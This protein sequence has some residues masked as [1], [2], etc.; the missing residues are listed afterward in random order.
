MQCKPLFLGGYQVLPIISNF[1]TKKYY[2]KNI[3]SIILI[4]ILF[5]SC[6]KTVDLKYKSNTS[7]I[8]IEGNITNE[9]IP[10]FVKITK[11]VSL[12]AT[13]NYPTIDNAVV[14][15]NDNAGN[16]ETLTPLGNGMYRT[17][18]ITGV[19]GRTYTLT[20]NAESKTYT[21]QT[22]MPLQVPFDSIKAE[23]TTFGGEVEYNI[24]PIYADPSVKGNNY[25]FELTVNNKL[26]NQHFVQ[27]DEVVNGAVNAERLQI[28]DNT[29]KL[30]AGD[31][32]MLKMQCI[33]KNVALYYTTL[34]LIG[35]SGPGGGTTPNNPPNNISNGALGIFSAHTVATK[36]V[37]LR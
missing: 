30:K 26:V 20:V 10:H 28:D 12:T 15:I 35:D 2:M 33:D 18:S 25:R 37:T 3:L 7:R 36:K 29:L 14:V 5:T 8:I 32:L 34:A 21:A 23:Q 13:G 16:T 22:T 1:N 24:I 31:S 19:I 27:N 4:A 11:S 17:N 9:P 6:E